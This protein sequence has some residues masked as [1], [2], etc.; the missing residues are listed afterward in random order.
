MN[1][2]ERTHFIISAFL[3]LIL[4][5]SSCGQSEN[6]RV[7]IKNHP[8]GKVKLV[9]FIGD[10][11]VSVKDKAYKNG[12]TFNMVGQKNGMYRI[13]IKEAKNR[14]QQTKAVNFIYN[15]EN[16]K[17]ETTYN[18]PQKDLKVI[19]SREN[20]IYQQ[21]L[22]Y[23][24]TFERKMNL[25]NRMIDQYPTGDP[26][27]KKV[28]KKYGEVQKAHEAHI[29][30]VVKKFPETY[31]SHVVKSYKTPYLKPQLS[32]KERISYLKE[33][34]LNTIDFQDTLL[35]RTPRIGQKILRYLSLYRQPG[36]S[37]S[38]QEEAF[39]EAV[40]EILMH[41]YINDKMYNY[42]LDYLVKG[43]EQYKMEKVLTHIYEKNLA[44]KAC[45]NNNADL[46]KR[47]KQYAMLAPGKKAPNI[48]FESIEGR[49]FKLSAMEK[50]VTLLLFYA[51]W[52]GHCQQSVPAI[53][54]VYKKYRSK[55][56]EVVAISLDEDK[57]EYNSFLAQKRYDWINY[58]DY[59]KWESPLVK[60]YNIYA[61]PTMVLVD[62]NQTIIEKPITVKELKE[63][64]EKLNLE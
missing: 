23:H 48:S 6:L 20:R 17:L 54:E 14:R 11:M 41:A 49:N 62:N 59:K 26:F 5:L 32:Q 37:P 30:S 21:F 15:N 7:V 3:L 9:K 4:S 58:C 24:R 42:V 57:E 18:N 64:L 25:L 61:T 47:L 28:M 40:D 31:A 55:G 38:E 13:V 19:H 51:S 53:Y 10:R 22:N 52:C 2:M 39:I 12:L 16:I 44:D 35:I 60:K 56:F 29:D 63:E 27:Y 46:K 50:P 33:Y 8:G 34:F 45:K 36:M 43:F 1:K